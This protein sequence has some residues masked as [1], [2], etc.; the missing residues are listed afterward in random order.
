MAGDPARANDYFGAC[1]GDIDIRKGL[2]YVRYAMQ[3]KK[4]P[5]FQV[6]KEIKPMWKRAHPKIFALEKNNEGEK[7]I[8]M[9]SMAGIP[10]MGITTTGDVS[11][12]GRWEV[13]DK[14]YTV[15]WIQKMFRNHR[16]IF[17]T[18]H[19]IYMQ[20]LIDQLKQVIKQRTPNGSVTYK[21]M[22]NRHDDLFSAF[23]ILCHLARLYIGVD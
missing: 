8:E 12:H 2:L 13:M 3:W 22:R 1:G 21:A 20:M 7:A 23:L 16:I 9:F 15:H 10:V 11:D 5:F 6:A 14:A 4:T 19:S 17:P 18:N